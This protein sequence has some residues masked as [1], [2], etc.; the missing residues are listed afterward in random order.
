MMAIPYY[1]NMPLMVVKHFDGNFG[2]LG[3]QLV[4]SSI[5]DKNPAAPAAGSGQTCRP[6]TGPRKLGVVKAGLELR[7]HPVGIVG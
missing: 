1:N 6:R 7:H 2:S 5:L 4:V 3:E